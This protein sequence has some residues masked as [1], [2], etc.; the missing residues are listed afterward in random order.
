MVGQHSTSEPNDELVAI[1]M[2]DCT[3]AYKLSSPCALA[4]LPGFALLSMPALKRYECQVAS[5]LC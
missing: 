4:G 1:G 2:E 5:T 3:K